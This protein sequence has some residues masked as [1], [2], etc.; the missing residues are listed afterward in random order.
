LERDPRQADR[1]EAENRP[2]VRRDVADAAE[3]A[4]SRS[5][6]SKAGRHN[7][8]RLE[9]VEQMA[10]GRED[11][12]VTTTDGAAHVLGLAGFFRDD[13]LISH[14]GSFGIVDSTAAQQEHTV[15]NAVAQAALFMVRSISAAKTLQET[16][17]LCTDKCGKSACKVLARSLFLP[18]LRNKS[19]RKSIGIS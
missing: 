4:A 5:A 11:F 10:L 15:N 3:L 1:V 12:S 2:P 19:E 8:L 16:L 7:I 17:Q 18:A 6:A 13:D 14:D 9:Q